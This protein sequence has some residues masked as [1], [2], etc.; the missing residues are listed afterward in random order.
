MR[1]EFARA[2]DAKPSG[3]IYLEADG[4]LLED[5][6]DGPDGHTLGCYVAE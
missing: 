2:A 1:P 3:D 4:P 6:A 5:H